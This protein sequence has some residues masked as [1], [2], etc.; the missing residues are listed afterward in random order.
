[1]IHYS[2]CLGVV[3]PTTVVSFSILLASL[4]LLLRHL[5]RQGLL[6]PCPTFLLLLLLLDDDDN[7]VADLPPYVQPEFQF[8]SNLSD[9]HFG[10]VIS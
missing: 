7:A 2:F 10:E 5:E 1:M 8:C 3:Y 9:L 4:L 6:V